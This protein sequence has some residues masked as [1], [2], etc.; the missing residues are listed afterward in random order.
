MRI[1]NIPAIIPHQLLKRLGMV[2]ILTFAAAERPSLSRGQWQPPGALSGSH[3][4]GSKVCASCHLAESVV[5]PDTPMAQT[6]SPIAI[7][8][9]LQSHPQ[10]SGQL[11]RYF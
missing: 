4:V 11:G 8:Q 2:F 9:V 5:Q 7:S 3:Y 1:T 6:L 10:L